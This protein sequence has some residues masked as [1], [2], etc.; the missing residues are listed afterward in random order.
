LLP[1]AGGTQVTIFVQ[2][3]WGST[4]AVDVSLDD[5]V[6][7]LKEKILEKN[8]WVGTIDSFRL[9]FSGKQLENA[10]NLRHWGSWVMLA[11]QGAAGGLHQLTDSKGNGSRSFRVAAEGPV[12]FSALGTLPESV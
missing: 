4:G 10:R 6:E 8:I 3:L 9:I 1:T 11:L 12:G 5:T 7:D 2:T